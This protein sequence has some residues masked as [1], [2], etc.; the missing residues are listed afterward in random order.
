MYKINL[1][2]E[3]KFFKTTR[4]DKIL[5]IGFALSFSESK[6]AKFPPDFCIWINVLRYW[7]QF[8]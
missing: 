3:I 8:V 6:N 2:F 5:F 1:C 4:S 7:C